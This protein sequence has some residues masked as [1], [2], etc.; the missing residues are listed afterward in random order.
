M[1]SGCVE[2]VLMDG[3]LMDLVNYFSKMLNKKLTGDEFISLTSIQKFRAYSWLKANKINFDPVILN[4]K[5]QISEIASGEN[6]DS[7]K[8]YEIFGNSG[9]KGQTPVCNIS[10]VYGVGIDIQKISEVFPDGIPEDIKSKQEFIDIFTAREM[11]YAE[12]TVKPIETLAGIFSVKEAIIKSIGTPIPLVSLE[13][14]PNQQ[15][16]PSIDGFDIS[17]SHSEDYVVAIAIK[18]NGYVYPLPT[19]QGA[20]RKNKLSFIQLRWVDYLIF[21]LILSLFALSLVK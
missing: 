12:G 6:L 9:L 15:G 19:E 20:K 11:S 14:L 8:P 21:A 13:I 18:K 3:D 17:I 1:S 7:V 4:R 5:F 10:N 2:I 16:K